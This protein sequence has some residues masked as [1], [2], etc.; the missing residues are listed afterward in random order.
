[1]VCLPLAILIVLTFAL[2]ASPEVATPSSVGTMTILAFPAGEEPGVTAV[3]T[4]GQVIA[5]QPGEEATLALGTWDYEQCGVSVQ[6]FIPVDA[7][8]AWSVN[9]ATGA[10]IDPA[11]GL[12]GID[13]ATTGNR[14]F[15]VTARVEDGQA[16]TTEVYVYTPETNPFVGTWHEVAQRSCADGTEVVPEQPIRELVFAADGQFAVTWVPFES[17]V[18]YWGRYVFDPAIGR[19]ALAVTGSIQS[20]DDIDGRGTFAIDAKGDLVLE[21]IWLGTSQWATEGTV[22][23]GHRFSR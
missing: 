19:L 16:V 12:V 18:D 9:P 2:P 22:N 5:L 6:C 3:G 17:Y 8:A 15:T 4:L 10:R 23:C 14:R 21:D 20:P 11:S 7:R 13:P 1:M